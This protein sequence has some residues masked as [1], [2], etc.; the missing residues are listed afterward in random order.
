MDEQRVETL[1][2]DAAAMARDTVGNLAAQT[3]SNLQGKIEQGK[4]ILDNAKAGAGDAIEKA[5]AVVRDVSAAGAQAA[6]KA[7]E[8]MQDVARGV[9]DRATQ[10]A[11]AL[12]QQGTN[13]G[14]YLSR[15]AAE[16]PLTALLLAAA[17]GYTL[18]YLVHRPR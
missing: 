14:G 2:A 17:L 18:A 5:T 10:A 16:Q 4:A 1:A 12:Y 3:Q 9:G 6:A 11:T 15:Y 7:N 13:A 8:V